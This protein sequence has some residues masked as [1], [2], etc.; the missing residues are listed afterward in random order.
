VTLARIARAAGV[1]HQTVINHFGGKEVVVVAVAEL[2][3]EQTESARY[4]AA[5]HTADLPVR[6]RRHRVAATRDQLVRISW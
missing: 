4:G 6:P 3:K 2:L 5:L 1:S